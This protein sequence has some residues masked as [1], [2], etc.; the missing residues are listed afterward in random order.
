[1]VTLHGETP[2]LWVCVA[3]RPADFTI[4]LQDPFPTKCIFVNIKVKTRR[5]T[6]VFYLVQSGTDFKILYPMQLCRSLIKLVFT[7]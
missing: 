6:S 7:M 3:M 1:M 2:I 4:T 5:H